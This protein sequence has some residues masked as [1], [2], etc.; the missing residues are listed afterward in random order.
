MMTLDILEYCRVNPVKKCVIF[1]SSSEYGSETKGPRKET[2]PLNPKT[3]YEGTKCAAT[4]LAQAWSNTYKIPV[5]VIRPFT[6]YGPGEK[7]NKLTQ[8]LKRCLR[9]REI[10]KLG[11]GVHDYIYID[12]FVDATF[13]VTFFNEPGHF[14]IVN[15]GSGIQVSNENFVR[16]AQKAIGKKIHVELVDSQKVYD[17]E[18]WVCDT[19]LL[20][21]KYGFYPKFRLE[22]GLKRTLA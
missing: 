17:S 22:D 20:S 10:L 11:P 3:I 15:I 1:G 16:A 18:C 4:L 7:P 8:V 12:D 6:V 13:K 21:H 14:N 19:T 2:D 5:T 9:N